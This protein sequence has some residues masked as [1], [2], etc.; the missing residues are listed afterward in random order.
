MM[1]G[2]GGGVDGDDEG[3]ERRKR[4]RKVDE[5]LSHFI[6]SLICNS[7]NMMGLTPRI[8]TTV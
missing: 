1:D 7:L 8:T 2:G 3:L 4:R 6:I 5:P